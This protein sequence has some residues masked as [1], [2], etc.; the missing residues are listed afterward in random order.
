MVKLFGP[1][2]APRQLTPRIASRHRIEEEQEEA[3]ATRTERV[4]ALFRYS[5]L[6]TLPPQP[7]RLE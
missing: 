1:D 2:S 5:F 4:T 6:T 7:Q 3:G